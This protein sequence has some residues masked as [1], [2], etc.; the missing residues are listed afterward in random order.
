MF[1]QSLELLLRITKRFNAFQVLEWFSFLL[2]VNCVIFA[3]TINADV[4]QAMVARAIES[5]KT[6]GSHLK[7]EVQNSCCCQF[8]FS[9]ASSRLYRCDTV[10]FSVS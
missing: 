10:A 9:S 4:W 3:R 5:R 6:L 1:E 7:E 2:W 8:P